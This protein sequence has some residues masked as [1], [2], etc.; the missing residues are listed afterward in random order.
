MQL[1][2]KHQMPV[3]SVIVDIIQVELDV[4]PVQQSPAVQRVYKLQRRVQLVK[5]DI[6]CQVELVQNV[7]QP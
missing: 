5:V 6:I 1:A 7:H 2:P 3:R 4:Q